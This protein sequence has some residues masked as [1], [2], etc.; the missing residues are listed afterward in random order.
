MKNK[1]NI[2]LVFTVIVL[3]LACMVPLVEAEHKVKDKTMNYSSIKIYFMDWTS[4]RRSALTPNDLRQM[5]L[6]YME[7]SDSDKIN[8]IVNVVFGK[9]INGTAFEN[10][11]YISARMVVDFLDEKGNVDTVFLDE[12]FIYYEKQKKYKTLDK[13][14]LKKLGT[15]VNRNV[16]NPIIIGE[17]KKTPDPDKP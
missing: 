6:L 11:M 12:S 15:I 9:S 2:T 17:K 1:E 7:I 3:T 10:E 5:H 8:E 13:E 4:M 16:W 14:L